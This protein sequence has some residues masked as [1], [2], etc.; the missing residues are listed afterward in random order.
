[1]RKPNSEENL[2]LYFCHG[3]SRGGR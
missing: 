1:M 2:N 3:R